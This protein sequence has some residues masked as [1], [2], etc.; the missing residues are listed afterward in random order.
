MKIWR[1]EVSLS[2]LLIHK[3]NLK[4][5][6][7]SRSWKEKN[8]LRGYSGER[9][10][11]SARVGKADLERRKGLNTFQRMNQQFRVTI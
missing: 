8:S 4:D 1:R 6:L 9:M 11:S 7:E 3:L 2:D 5:E 10:D